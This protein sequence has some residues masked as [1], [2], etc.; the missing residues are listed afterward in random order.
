VVFD[1]IRDRSAAESAR[2]LVL[3][4]LVDPSDTPDDPEEFYDHQLVGLSAYTT[5]GLEVGEVTEVVHAGGQ[6]LLAISTTQGEALVPFVHALVPVIDVPAGRLEI[7][8]RPGLL[9]P[10]EDES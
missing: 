5:E 2:G 8:D 9:A 3:T 6:D 4:V 1:E 7:A 10:L